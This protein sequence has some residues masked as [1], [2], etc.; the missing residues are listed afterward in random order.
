MRKPMLG[1]IMAPILFL[2]MLIA[3][4]LLLCQYYT[5]GSYYNLFQSL[6]MNS[7]LEEKFLG[8]IEENL[9][10]VLDEDEENIGAWV[11]DF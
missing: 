10:C 7:L 6:F 5:F 8:E 3:F 9:D 1:Y 2:L 11:L 4:G